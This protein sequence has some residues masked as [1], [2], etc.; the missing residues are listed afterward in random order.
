MLRSTI[1]PESI[2]QTKE[3][4]EIGYLY[5]QIQAVD[6]WRGGCGEKL[7]QADNRQECLQST[8]LHQ[9]V[10]RRCLL[11]SCSGQNIQ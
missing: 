8:S 10:A 2:Y 11:S 9:A 3:T 6:A 1:I 4:M 7:R 5:I